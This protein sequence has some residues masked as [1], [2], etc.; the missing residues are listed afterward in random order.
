MK[1]YILLTFS[2]LIIFLIALKVYGDYDRDESTLDC[3]LE[4]YR[5]EQEFFNIDKDS[6]DIAFPAIQSKFSH[7]FS[8]TTID[9]KN[10]VFLDDTLN[11][12]LDSV[13]LVFGELMPGLSALQTGFCNYQNYFP[14][15]EL[16][17]YT[18]I[19]K[20]FDYRTPV[21]FADSKLFVSLHL[22]LGKTHTFYKFLPEYI[23]YSHDAT[24]LPSSC[25]ITLAGRH[26]PYPELNNFLE[27][28]LHYS[29]AYLFAQKML[30]DI[31][32][33]E[34]F[35]CSQEKMMWCYKNES[36]IWRYMIERDYLFSS[37]MDLI[38]KFVSLAPFSQFG[39]PTDRDSPGSVGV[40]LGLQIWNMYMY[41]NKI[42]LVEALIETD[43]IKVLNKS[44]YK[45]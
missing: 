31:P 34:L 8:D 37:S 40:W 6:F 33:H 45:P 42:S 38:D 15:Q 16:S 27:T 18:F 14:E 25:F 5:F 22:F 12:V 19:D 20:S 36:A 10:D 1:K 11:Q 29:K 39:L 24:F 13:N 26:I 23:S 21:V 3:G 4:I 28:I 2:L 32:E 41:N 44:G 9:F 35:K 43:Y 30:P 7:F 17:I